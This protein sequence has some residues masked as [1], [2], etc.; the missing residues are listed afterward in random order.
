MERIPVAGPAGKDGANGAD[1]TVAGPAGKARTN[2]ADSTVAGPAGKD[3]TNRP[4]PQ[5][6]DLL[7]K[8]EQMGRIQQLL[9]CWCWDK[10]GRFHSCTAGKDGTNGRI[11]SCWTCW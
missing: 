8:M 5:L 4:I 1:S 9:T 11:H 10:W 2:G 6:L 3:G 7:E